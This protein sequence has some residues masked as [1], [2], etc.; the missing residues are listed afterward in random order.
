M[1]VEVFKVSISVRVYQSSWAVLLP[2]CMTS[3]FLLIR[4][5]FVINKRTM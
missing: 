4:L 3:C 5:D 1:E 2:A